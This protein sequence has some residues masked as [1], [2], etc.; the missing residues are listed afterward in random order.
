MIN[1][2]TLALVC[3][4]ALATGASAADIDPREIGPRIGQAH[5]AAKICPGA[6]LTPLAGSITTRVTASERAA[7]DS[8]VAE[9]TAAWT[10]AFDCVDV[11]PETKREL[12]CRKMKI[13]SCNA[14][15]Q[16]IGPEGT[17]LPG[18]LEFKAPD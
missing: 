3:S 11:D 17:A 9:V 4:L 16:E 1:P 18:L 10:K 13:L 8:G 2:S 7:F 12:A 15:W 14:A 5:S 6:R